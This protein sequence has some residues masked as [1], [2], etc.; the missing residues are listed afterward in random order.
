MHTKTQKIRRIIQSSSL[1]WKLNVQL[2]ATIINITPLQENAGCL[3][4]F[5][6][7]PTQETSLKQSAHFQTKLAEKNELQTDLKKVSCWNSTLALLI[8]NKVLK[9]YIPT[10]LFQKEI[11]TPSKFNTWSQQSL[12]GGMPR[13]NIELG[14]LAIFFRYNNSLFESIPRKV[15]ALR[16]LIKLDFSALR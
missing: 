3:N 9:T 6:K 16:S 15:G 11:R 12:R 2:T 4:I 14:Q 8:L 1:L 7:K 5:S 13:S 10:C